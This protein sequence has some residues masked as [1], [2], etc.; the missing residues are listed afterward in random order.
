MCDIACSPYQGLTTEYNATTDVCHQFSSE[1]IDVQ[2]E[3][4]MYRDFKVRGCAQLVTQK[5]Y[6]HVKRNLQY[7]TVLVCSILNTAFFV[8]VYNASF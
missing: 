1:H 6:A 8:Q 4:R 7:N 5:L 3:L 2:D